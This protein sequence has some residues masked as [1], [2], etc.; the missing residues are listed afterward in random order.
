MRVDDNSIS[1]SSQKQLGIM[2]YDLLITEWI[3]KEAEMLSSEYL[4]EVKELEKEF[5]E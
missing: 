1:K 2:S 5:W 3:P 4:P